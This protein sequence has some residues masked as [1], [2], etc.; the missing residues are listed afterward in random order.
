MAG[1]SQPVG[2]GATAC[3]TAKLIAYMGASSLANNQHQLNDSDHE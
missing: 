2:N 3:V 1:V